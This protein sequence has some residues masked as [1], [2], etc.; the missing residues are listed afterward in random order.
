MAG[1]RPTTFSNQVFPR[2]RSGLT[3]VPGIGETVVMSP[4]LSSMESIDDPDGT[5]A[6]I[7]GAC[8]G[9]TDV[10]GLRARLAE[11]GVS[12]PR[13]ALA[14]GVE[15][16]TA[17]GLLVD[18]SGDV[19]D[20]WSNQRAY[21]EH[22]SR[23]DMDVAAAQARVRS[24]RVLVL[25]AGG[26]GSWLALALAMMGVADLMVVD[27][28]VVEDR[29]LTRQPYPA[30]SAGRRKVEVLGEIVTRLR[31]EL[32]YAGVDLRV[33]R[34]DDLAVLVEGR[35][36]VACCAD[37]PSL[38]AISSLIARVCIPARVAHVICGY[39][40]ATGRVGPFWYPRRRPLPC[41]GCQSLHKD[42]GF[43]PES[44]D[45]RRLGLPTAVS[46]AQPQL[47]AALAASEI[48]HFRVGLQPATAGR[49]FALDSLTLDTRR[50]RV[51]LRRECPIC[52]GGRKRQLPMS[53]SAGVYQ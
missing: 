20:E 1:P 50:S 13:E 16:L 4:R 32:R 21:I 9:T 11:G 14:E 33:E 31:P 34:D 18:G 12:L 8:D 15:E 40:G 42:S 41:A 44:L 22:L 3:V 6:T 45:E 37:E 19:Q 39:H 47:V 30:D 25:G 23:G 17:A 10:D 36:V 26:T 7:L 2:L 28:D 24:T 27:P 53:L 43:G 48:L 35:D 49:L 52:L 51:P 38:D 29:N 5:W 46:V